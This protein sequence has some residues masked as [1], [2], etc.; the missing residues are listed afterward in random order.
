MRDDAGLLPLRPLAGERVAVITP[1][2]REL[3]PADSSAD[4][5]LALADA[6]RRH[7]PEVIDVR[8]AS[9][10][11][12]AEI[13]AAR[14]A[15]AG[16]AFAVVA[17]MA[18]NVQPSQAR[19][20]EAV[21]ES[22]TPTVTVAMRTPYDLA[23]YPR[24]G[25]TPVLV[26]DRAGQRRR[27]RGCALRSRAHRRPAARGHPRALSP[28]TW[29]GG[30]PVALIDEIREQPEVAARLLSEAGPEIAAVCETIKAADPS[31]VVIAARGTSDHAA[32]YAQYAMG[33]L[34]GLNVGLAT[35]SVHSLYGASPDY[36]R[37][38][39]I[40]ISQSGAS[41][42]VV[43]CHPRR[44]GAGCAHAGHHQHTRL[45]HGRGGRA[46]HRPA[47]RSRA[48][49]GGDQDLHRDAAGAGH[50]HCG[51]GRCRCRGRPGQGAPGAGGGP[52]PRRGSRAHRADQAGLDRC[53]VLGRGYHYATAREWSLK[54]KELAYVLADPYSSADFIH[55]PLALIEA[56]FPTFCV[57]PRGAT[58]GDMAEVIERLGGEL[59][60]RLLIVSDDEA[61]RARG[62]WSFAL[63]DDLARVA[64]AHRL[65]RARPAPRHAHDDGQGRDPEQP[66]SI[67]KVT[68]TN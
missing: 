68:L 40:G 31:H 55:G 19:L 21:L 63:P 51:P 52:R 17:T 6:V 22:G 11:D 54:L 43:G 1:Q 58:E 62:T 20:V 49:G 32:I 48:C 57:A 36:G 13:A 44:A 53:V 12:D 7:H 2:P 24:L 64:D 9:E 10:P 61:V 4:E 50:A 60:A 41:P 15:A 66:R 5:P 3:T 23:D 39:V 37:A 33:V 38:L 16:A 26:L 27:G 14:E 28:R 30:D 67:R 59:E 45:G 35:P 25:D 65:D 56:G 46:S 18:T 47:C 29:Y 34:A 42:D 8:V